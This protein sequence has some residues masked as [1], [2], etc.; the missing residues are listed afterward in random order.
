M[1]NKIMVIM[2]SLWT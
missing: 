2:L 1:M